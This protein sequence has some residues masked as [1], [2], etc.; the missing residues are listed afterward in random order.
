MSRQRNSTPNGALGEPSLDHASALIQEYNRKLRVTSRRIHELRKEYLD[1]NQR[2]LELSSQNSGKER[3]QSSLETT[4][5]FQRLD[6]F[7]SR[8][9]AYAEDVR[10]ITPQARKL[11]QHVSQLISHGTDQTMVQIELGLRVAELES[12]IQSAKATAHSPL[13]FHVP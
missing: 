12:A 8:H 2:R 10:A 5:W 6:E 7:R 9:D 13:G 4:L 3:N 11:A 1:A